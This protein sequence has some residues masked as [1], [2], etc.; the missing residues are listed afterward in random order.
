MALG[1]KRTKIWSDTGVVYSGGEEVY[2]AGEQPIAEIDNRFNYNVSKDIDEL[3]SEVGSHSSA[4]E[5]GGSDEINLSGL[6]IDDV[7]SFDS[8]GISTFQILDSHGTAAISVDF[9]AHEWREFPNLG[10]QLVVENGILM[11]GGALDLGASAIDS[12]H[13][14]IYDAAV[15][16]ITPAAL[17]V[18]NRLDLEGGEVAARIENRVSRPDSPSPGRLI[19]RTDKDQ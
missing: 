15:G 10:T 6:S 5:A 2:A 14:Q 17:L 11:T 12:D 1:D 16:A 19:Y 3:W 4:H 9:D 8:V 7:A 18:N 13:G